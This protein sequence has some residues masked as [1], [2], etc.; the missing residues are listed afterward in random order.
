MSTTIGF[1]V[2]SHDKPAQLL[3]LIR[4]LMKLYGNPPIV[5]H[6]DFSKCSLEGFDFP[7]EVTFVRPHIETKWGGI[8]VCLAFVAA[9]HA[10][11]QRADSPDWFVFLSGA[12][13]PVRPA[14]TVLDQLSLG[15]F[16][17]YLDHRL[18]EY[19]WTPDPSVKYA[20]YAFDSAAWVPLAY[21]RYVALRFWL[22]WYSWARRKP[23]KIIVGN[24]RSQVLIR[25]FTPFSE[26]LKCYG[27]SGW[28]TCNR[29]AAERLLAQNL[30]NRSL[31]AHYSRKFAADESLSQTI[32][33][34]QPDLKIS[35]NDMRYIDGSLGGPHQK[36]LGMEDVPGILASG[37][38]FARKF[39]LA[40][41]AEVFDAIDAAVDAASH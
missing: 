29:K 40:K 18:V 5:C 16:D 4:R 27:G 6:H 1:V 39:D 20:P 30:E 38:H 26:T 10:M 19:P 23:V 12:D 17:A 28:F 11:Y 3:R 14:Q 37:A 32:L 25:L 41:G 24:L 2:V 34:N 8:S 33:C 36:T 31:L 13:Y 22:P 35:K 15:G 9:L 7:K 21:D